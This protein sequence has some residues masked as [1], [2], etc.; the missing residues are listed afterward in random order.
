[1]ETFDIHLTA[2][3]HWLLRATLQGSLLVCLILAI[4]LALRNRLPARWHY[5]LW[6]VLLV[7]L[8][9]PWAPQSH[10]SIYNQL[11]DEELKGLDISEHGEEA[12][13]GFAIFTLE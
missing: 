1:M 8:V 9:L 12:Y 13:K 6:L 3:V 10:L 11:G 7:R 5:C 2:F 4:K